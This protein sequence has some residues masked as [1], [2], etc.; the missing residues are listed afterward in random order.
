MLQYDLPEHEQEPRQPGFWKKHSWWL[1]PLLVCDAVV[2]AWWLRR[3]GG[4]ASPDDQLAEPTAMT[5]PMEAVPLPPGIRYGYPTAQDHLLDTN[6]PGIY[7]P[8]GS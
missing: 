5:A 8:T 7:M 3:D 6:T 1:I 2:L 4:N